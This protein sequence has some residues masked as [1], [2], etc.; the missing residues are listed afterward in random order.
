[1]SLPEDDDLF[2]RIASATAKAISIAE[3]TLPPDVLSQIVAASERETSPVAK[4]ELAHI[5][6]NIRLAEER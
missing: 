4:R 6:E 1:M 5:L 3:I 2:E